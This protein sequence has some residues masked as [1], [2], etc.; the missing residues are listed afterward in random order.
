MRDK[1]TFF[2]WLFRRRNGVI[3]TRD[4]RYFV[5]SGATR[6]EIPPIITASLIAVLGGAVIVWMA[7]PDWLR[8]IL[9]VYML[10]MALYGTA[11]IILYYF[12]LVTPI[13]NEAEDGAA[14][15][16]APRTRSRQEGI[17]NDRPTYRDY[18]FHSE[19]RF[20]KSGNCYYTIAKEKVSVGAWVFVGLYSAVIAVLIV[21]GITNI[22]WPTWFGEIWLVSVPVHIFLSKQRYRRARFILVQEDTEDWQKASKRVF[23]A[24]GLIL[25]MVVVFFNLVMYLPGCF[26]VSYIR[27]Q[28]D[29]NAT[30]EM[31]V[32]GEGTYYSDENTLDES[33]PVTISALPNDDVWINIRIFHTPDTARLSLNGQPLPQKDQ[34]RKRAT[35]II[36]IQNYF[37]QGTFFS[38]P[39]NLL[40]DGS[41]LTLDCGDLHR[42]WVFSVAGEEGA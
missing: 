2:E 42:E 18:L 15:Y 16:S 9:L 31:G 23:S 19:N 10:A 39:G 34:L 22:I 1:P 21:L 32:S 30:I 6:K 17:T 25:W 27:S 38:I 5:V 26:T 12:I 8:P 13:F 20:V 37:E 28:S 4:G 29:R 7:E 36:D 35:S 40:H 14:R 11:L 3:K 33:V 41:T 24:A